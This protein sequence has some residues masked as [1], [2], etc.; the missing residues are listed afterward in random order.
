MRRVVVILIILNNIVG[1]L[2]FAPPSSRFPE[3]A[4]QSTATLFSE[5]ALGPSL[6]F[7]ANSREAVAYAT[8]RLIAPYRWALAGDP[9]TKA[10]IW[11]FQPA[12]PGRFSAAHS[13]DHAPRSGAGL[14]SMDEH[15]ARSKA[16][17][18]I[19]AQHRRV[20]LRRGSIPKRKR[21]LLDNIFRTL[22]A[23]RL[24]KLLAQRLARDILLTRDSELEHPEVWHAIGRLLRKDVEWLRGDMRLPDRQISNLLVR[25]SALDAYDII[26]RV[27]CK[28]HEFRH[29]RA[30][31]REAAEDIRP[32]E[33]MWKAINARVRK[34][35]ARSN[36]VLLLAAGTACAAL[37][38]QGNLLL[39]EDDHRLYGS[40]LF[41]TQVLGPIHD[42]LLNGLRLDR[43]RVSLLASAA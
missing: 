7:M 4:S 8:R 37:L 31:M 1:A 20:T 43:K 40:T 6:L 39:P 16:E 35:R 11:E 30:I 24:P 21:L 12:S 18:Y 29:P 33:A 10:E 38:R 23:E 2:P 17:E 36:W 34:A 15:A 26:W 28:W 25:M 14:P 42:A 27:I 9:R 3:F 41:G 5:S 19:R 13:K 32:W 22:M